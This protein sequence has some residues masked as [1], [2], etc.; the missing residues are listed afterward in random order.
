MDLKTSPKE[1]F[2]KY[3]VATV[4]AAVAV[5][6]LAGFFFRSSTISDLRANLEAKS[7][8][9]QKQSTN[10]SY[11][12]QLDEQLNALRE[13]N[14]QISGR[15]VNP[16][17]LAIN[18]QYFYKLETE[19]GAKLISAS[20]AT[21]SQG[22]PQVF[23]TGFK[24]VPYTISVQ[25]SFFQIVSFLRRLEQGSSYCRIIAASCSPTQEEGQD[26]GE[27]SAIALNLSIEILGKA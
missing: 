22:R 25:G 7:A 16:Q 2:K 6:V 13:A 26:K 21:L 17:E 10:I 4:S 1:F 20:P 24:P 19:T 8:E 3:P 5:I 15:L 11:S 23:K 9:A 18:L 14:K 12:A 27:P